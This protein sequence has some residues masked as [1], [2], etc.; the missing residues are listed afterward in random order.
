MG[1][2]RTVSAP[3]AAVWDD[4]CR[5]TMSALPLGHGLEGVGLRPARLGG[6]RHQHLAGRT[7]LDVTPIPVLF[8]ERPRVV[9]S[10]GLSQAGRLLGGLT[11]PR[12]DAGALRAWSQP[13]WIKVAMEFRL[14]S[15]PAG[16]VLSTETRI[17]ATDPTTRR[18]F[19]AH[20]FLIPPRSGPT[21][22]P[23]LRVIPSP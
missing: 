16:T 3:A 10:A 1:R 23:L 6:R 14:E 20:W 5:V 9:I 2:C 22:P 13:G 12:L 7:F 17:L 19:P 15:T 8:S 11:P 21:R 4:L 18:P